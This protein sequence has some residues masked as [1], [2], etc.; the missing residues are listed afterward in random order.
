M[1]YIARALPALCLSSLGASLLGQQSPTTFELGFSGPAALEG[2]SSVRTASYLCTLTHS[3]SGQGAAEWA[4]SLGA[5][6]G[7]ITGIS[8]EGTAAQGA[9]FQRSELTGGARNEGAIS[10]VILG[11]E[12]QPLAPNSTQTIARI[13]VAAFVPPAGG[14]TRL[15]YI[16]GK[17]GSEGQ[18]ISNRVLQGN[19]PQEYKPS[20]RSLDI[21]HPSNCPSAELNLGFSSKL[22]SSS[23][24][25][26]GILGE[27]G[28]GGELDV[29]TPAGRLG[30]AHLYANIVSRMR[31]DLGVQGWSLSIAVDGDASP[32]SA[33][34]AGT[35]V[36][37]HFL[38][39]FLKTEVVNAARNGNQKGVITALVLSFTQ[40]RTLPPVGTESVLDIGL[41]AD[42]LQDDRDVVADLHFRDFLRGSGQP[43]QNAITVGGES[44]PACNQ[45][46]VG[47]ELR[48][49]KAEGF[50]LRG[51]SNND[52]KV[53]LADAIWILNELFYAGPPFS[54]EDAAD[55]NDD[56]IV[57]ISDAGYII[58][59]QFGG[60]FSPP[61]PFPVCGTDHDKSEDRLTCLKSQS[62]CP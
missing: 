18:P 52:S 21:V 36:E 46:I 49:I 30:S 28:A 59:Y 5:D 33:T 44:R 19:D 2:G 48:F 62:A 56:G 1:K 60:S 58:R 11:N 45:N 4:I 3:G 41:T 35:S 13:D 55:A 29:G 12:N 57:D 10:V 51:N 14:L 8:L 16:D 7:F 53:N 27:V 37:K 9:R 31:P 34:T 54:C 25:F 23:I 24:P 38:G 15:R 17:R 22:V 50:F 47:M 42:R 40:P 43:I 32:K 61:S 39:G 20:L 6:N 26:A